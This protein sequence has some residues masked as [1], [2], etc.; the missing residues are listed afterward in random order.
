LNVILLDSGKIVGICLNDCI[1]I[2]KQAAAV[3]PIAKIAIGQKSFGVPNID[4]GH[5]IKAITIVQ[6]QN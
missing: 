2:N 3:Q 1:K 5:I 6:S 4:I